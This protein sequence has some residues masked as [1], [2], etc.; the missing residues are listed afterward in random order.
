M[1]TSAD[2]LFDVGARDNMRWKRNT[3]GIY[4]Y[5]NQ[6]GRPEWERSRA[7][8]EKWYQEF[9]DGARRDLRGRFRRDGKNTESAFFEI[10]LHEFFRKLGC[11]I[12]VHPGVPRTSR[13]PDFLI[14]QGCNAFYLEAVARSQSRSQFAHDLH[15]EDALD[16]LN[17]IYSPHFGVLVD[18][19]GTLKV[20]LPKSRIQR[21][22]RQRLKTLDPQEYPDGE[23]IPEPIEV[24]ADGWRLKGQLVRVSEPDDFPPEDRGFILTFPVSGGWDNTPSEML[25][26]LQGKAGRYGEPELPI[27]IALNWSDT[28]GSR[29]DEAS[30]V[31]ALYA[32]HVDN[33]RRPPPIRVTFRTDTGEPVA[34]GPGQ[35]Q[36]GSGLFVRANGRPKYSRVA[37]VLIFH[38]ATPYLNNLSYRLYLNWNTPHRLPVVMRELRHVAVVEGKGERRYGEGFTVSNYSRGTV[39]RATSIPI[40]LDGKWVL[41]WCEGKSAEE[42]L[43]IASDISQ[44][45]PG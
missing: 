29:H 16:K 18:V 33:D 42:I 25:K 39:T 13:N 19:E 32:G 2:K 20:D 27:V 37:A 30:V 36:K 17:D 45:E 6:S 3:E 26:V 11:E 31:E 38:G 10:L 12:E 44:A 40:P 21:P 43:G 1:N 35:S 4:T 28:S 7:I 22:F 9:P 34:I 5:L 24:T 15:T 41:D 23:S 8:L 14:R